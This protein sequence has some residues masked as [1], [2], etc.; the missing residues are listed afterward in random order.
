MR[1][2]A[3]DQPGVS[4]SYSRLLEM[5][6]ER[7]KKYKYP[8]YIKNYCRMDL[9]LEELAHIRYCRYLLDVPVTYH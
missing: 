2:G 4:D 1:K 9:T 7:R 8:D 6:E 3:L 5:R